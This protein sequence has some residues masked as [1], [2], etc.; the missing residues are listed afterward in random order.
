MTDLRGY[1]LGSGEG[2]AWWF[3][4]TLMTVKAGGDDTHDSFTLIEFGAPIGFG[5]PLHIHHRE[6]EAFYLLDGA[7]QVVCGEDRWEAGPGSYV[8]A[9]CATRVRCELGESMSGAA[10]HCAGTVRTVC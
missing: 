1:H 3:L 10:D 2:K 9:R 7:M 4:D 8:A 5:P 6:D